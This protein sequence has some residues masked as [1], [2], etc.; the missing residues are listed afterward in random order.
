[1]VTLFE[2]LSTEHCNL[3][4]AFE[5]RSGHEQLTILSF[6]LLADRISI[7]LKIHGIS[8]SSTPPEG[9]RPL[10]ALSL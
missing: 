1:M 10:F 7:G 9:S 3:V 2:R 4:K 5:G 6:N 8:V